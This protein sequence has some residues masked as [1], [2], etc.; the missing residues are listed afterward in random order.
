MK[1]CVIGASGY[2]G[3]ELVR[4]LLGH[5]R[6]ELSVITSRALDGQPVEKIIPQVVGNSDG[7]VFSN[8]SIEQLCHQQDLDIFFL[9]LPHGTAASYA[10]ALLEAEKKVIDLSADFRLNSADTYKEFYGEEHPDKELLQTA[11]YGLPE[12]ARPSW[13]KSKLIA[14][15]GCYPTSILVPLAPLLKR[16]LVSNTDIV[17]NSMSGISGAGRNASEKLLY[18][19]RNENASAYG[20]P[21][22]RHLSEIEEQLSL[23][24]NQQVVVSFHPHLA[25]MNRGICTTIS[26]PTNEN[27]EIS[28][29]YERWNQEYEKSSFVNVLPTGTFPEVAHVVGSNRIDISA[30][31]DSRTNRLV[32][33][34]TEDNLIKG[35]GGQAIQSMNICEGFTETEGLV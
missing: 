10:I 2:T 32:I 18:C 30:H 14:S 34:S 5:P 13:E 33:C 25:P 24:A 7:L 15:P 31:L 6:I 21:K 12:L 28:K 11:Q 26:V 9:A 22:H 20:L 35:A 8:P 23:F 3:R 4:L 1:A 16:N 17:I 29:V 19:E 27:T